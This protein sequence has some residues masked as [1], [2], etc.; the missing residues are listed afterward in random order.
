[1]HT[2][3]VHSAVETQLHAFFMY[4][5]FYPPYQETPGTHSIIDCAGPRAGLDFWEI[6]INT[7]KIRTLRCSVCLPGFTTGPKTNYDNTSFISSIHSSS[8]MLQYRSLHQ[9]TTHAC[10]N[11]PFWITFPFGVTAFDT[12]SSDELKQSYCDIKTWVF[13]HVCVHD[14][15]IPEVTP[16]H[17][18]Q[19]KL[20]PTLYIYRFG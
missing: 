17:M 20:I 18:C 19:I 8:Q 11:S 4:G 6:S 7:I 10:E 1:M 12:P 15:P 9:H 5:P 13:V 14:N 16:C 3:K 2:K